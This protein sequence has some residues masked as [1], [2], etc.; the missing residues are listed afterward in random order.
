MMILK[1]LV[2]TLKKHIWSNLTVDLNVFP[3]YEHYYD[4]E[5]KIMRLTSKNSEAVIRRC[6]VKE[7]FLE[8]LQNSQ[9]NTCDLRLET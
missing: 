5:M 9:G 6:S 8:N 4:T 3:P 2:I 7:V 1:I